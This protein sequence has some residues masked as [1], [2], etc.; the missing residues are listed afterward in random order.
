M[1]A[2]CPLAARERRQKPGR[3]RAVKTA[4]PL[5]ETIPSCERRYLAPVRKR[6]RKRR[7]AERGLGGCGR[8]V[9]WHETACILMERCW[10]E[11]QTL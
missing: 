10:T 6:R 4:E 1:K 11:R 7:K 8:G 3:W 2:G 5:S 9:C